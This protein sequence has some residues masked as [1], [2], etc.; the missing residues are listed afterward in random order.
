MRQKVDE[1]QDV[2]LSAVPL[3][4]PATL[5]HELCEG[6]AIEAKLEPVD[7][8]HRAGPCLVGDSGEAAIDERTIEGGI[9]GNDE[10]TRRQDF[11]GCCLIDALAGQHVVGEARELG[12]A[13]IER[14]L[15]ILSPNPRRADLEDAATFVETK[16]LDGKFDDPVSLA[17]EPG[18]LYVDGNAH[19]RCAMGRSIMQA[20][21]LCQPAQDLE[22]RM[23]RKHAGGV[24]KARLEAHHGR[25]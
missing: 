3:V 15:R 24:G 5:R 17:I 6:A 8:G 20:L 10:V 7:L 12:D 19:A 2:V 1:R 22:V 23:C 25:V 9:M 11:D 21:H 16:S 4:E 13:R 18:G 14:S